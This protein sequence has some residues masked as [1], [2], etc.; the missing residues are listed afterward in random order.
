[1][2]IVHYP[3]YQR[4]AIYQP[5]DNDAND[6]N[7]INDINHING[8]NTQNKKLVYTYP[9][10]PYSTI[11]I[12]DELFDHIPLLS[13]HLL[14]FPIFLQVGPTCG[15]YALKSIQPNIDVSHLLQ[16]AREM[17]MSEMGEIYCVHDLAKLAQMNGIESIVVPIDQIDNY[18][19]YKCILI[20]F[21][22]DHNGVS[23]YGG[24]NAHWGIVWKQFVQEDLAIITHSSCPYYLIEK[25]SKV[26]ESNKQLR[27]STLRIND[28]WI[29]QIDNRC[30]CG[31][32][33]L[34]L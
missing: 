22:A 34:I 6:I 26:V 1:M 18:N 32:V 10:P 12:E 30:L 24:K 11:L 15:L 33:I 7:G 23:F 8:I 31:F 20:P 4:I 28:E 27:E 14:Y 9:V 5:N 13:D 2:L 17:G 16:Q 21:D 19:Q 3:H 25:W 29:H